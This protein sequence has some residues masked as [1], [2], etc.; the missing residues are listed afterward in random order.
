MTRQ[1]AI[2][3]LTDKTKCK[4]CKHQSES[5]R[6]DAINI[7]V[8]SMEAQEDIMRDIT[9]LQG[10]VNGVKNKLMVGL[11]LAIIDNNLKEVKS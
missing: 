7:A 8:K 1:D 6:Q 4:Y 11:C 9:D 10:I 2:D 5:C 3:C